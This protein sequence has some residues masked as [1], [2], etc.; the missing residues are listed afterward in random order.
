MKIVEIIIV[1]VTAFGLQILPMAA[2]VGATFFVTRN[3]SINPDVRSSNGIYINLDGL[4]TLTPMCRIQCSCFC[5]NIS[6]STRIVLFLNQGVY[7]GITESGKRIV[8]L[9]FWT[10]MR[11]AGCTETMSSEST[12]QYNTRQSCQLSTIV[13]V[14]SCQISVKSSQ[15][16]SP[17]YSSNSI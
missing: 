15:S 5:A 4:H 14:K 11:R 1:E 2:V 9:V 12:Y 8:Q 16:E 17:S 6:V 10:T 13:S 3:L 7:V